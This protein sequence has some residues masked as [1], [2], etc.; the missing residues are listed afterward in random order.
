[1]FHRDARALLGSALLALSL[2]GCAPNFSP[3]TYASNAAQI[4]NKVDQ[5]VVVGVRAISISADATLGTATGGAAG[6]IAGSQ[7]GQGAAGAIGALGGSVAGGMVGNVVTHAAGDTD[8]YEY[9]VRKTDGELLS[10]T[11]KDPQPLEIGTHVLVIE[12]PQA[13]IVIDYTVPIDGSQSHPAD[14]AKQ[15]ITPI[16]APADHPKAATDTA[17]VAAGPVAASVPA[18]QPPPAAIAPSVDA[19]G[20]KKLTPPPA[21]A[22]PK[23]ADVP[24]APVPAPKGN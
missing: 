1:M 22:P 11:Q 23:P 5:G 15:T 19:G 20:D 4:A 14:K 7:I 24:A 2:A 13:R 10:V 6:G 16:P 8:G 21:D 3:D 9:I 12:G 17:P 18:T